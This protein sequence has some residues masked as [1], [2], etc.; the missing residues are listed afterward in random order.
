MNIRKPTPRFFILGIL[1]LFGFIMIYTNNLIYSPTESYAQSIDNV[2]HLNAV[3]TSNGYVWESNQEIN[4]SI[5]MQTQTENVIIV[6]SIPNDPAPHKL[7][8]QTFTGDEIDTS[9]V[10][11]DG[12]STDLLFHPT[13]KGNLEYICMFHPQSMHGIINVS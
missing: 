1:T 10:I 12:G 4:P 8:I 3:A 13:G 9:E 7:I 5:D 2:I 11:S 6:S